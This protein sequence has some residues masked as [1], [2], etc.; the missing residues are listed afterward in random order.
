LVLRAIRIS[1]LPA[2]T[3]PHGTV[4]YWPQGVAGATAA[5]VRQVRSSRKAI[6]GPEGE[7]IK[8]E[9]DNLSAVIEWRTL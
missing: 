9:D 6:A 2:L 7:Q 1:R 4:E 8:T 3:G 5:P